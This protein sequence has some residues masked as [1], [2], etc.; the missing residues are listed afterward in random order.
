R[1]MK[2]FLTVTMLS[3]GVPMIG[4]GDE[5]RRSQSGNNNAYCQDNETSWFDWTL[6]SRHAD[7]LRFVKLLIKRRLQRDM[8]PELH[9]LCLN[10]LLSRA[11]K[12]WHGVKI[13]RPDWSPW[14]HSLAFGAELS[15]EK[16]L[17]HM[18]M[19]AYWEP[20]EFEL[21]PLGAQGGGPWR[22]WIDTT[23]DSP[24]DI[25]EWKS[26]QPVSAETYL[27]GPRSVVVLFA[28]TGDF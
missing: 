12:A 17:F 7:M 4:M 22:R 27:A 8:D 14:S 16:L 28:S 15:K 26:L 11:H 13:G 21:P 5:V 24:H 20:L 6:V 2:N 19:N 3:F 10:Q 1:Q 9:H 23:F 18:I 25:V